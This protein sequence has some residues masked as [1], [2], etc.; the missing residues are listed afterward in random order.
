MI[1]IFFLFSF[2]LVSRKLIP[3]R[4]QR[5]KSKL[6]Q[7]SHHGRG[8][9][10]FRR[11]IWQ[12]LRKNVGHH[13]AMPESRSH[14]RVIRSAAFIDHNS[15]HE[16][17]A[18]SSLGSGSSS[19]LGSGSSVHESSWINDG[20]QAEQS[21]TPKE[22]LKLHGSPAIAPTHKTKTS[23]QK[24]KPESSNSNVGVI[25]LLKPANRRASRTA[26]R[27][28][29][30]SG[31]AGSGSS[32]DI[33]SGVHESSGSEKIEEVIINPNVAQPQ[34][35]QGH[36]ETQGSGSITCVGDINCAQGSG[37]MEMNDGQIMASEKFQHSSV[38]PV[39]VPGD[40]LNKAVNIV[41]HQ[42]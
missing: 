9:A 27:I 5:P 6:D 24:Q 14:N 39:Y 11:S 23:S 29:T 15:K 40:Q 3:E 30:G 16:E 37:S 7:G 36:G 20:I 18:D 28:F 34:F 2:L 13:K 41:Y 4:G 35:A 10:I 42:I 22:S 1:L 38:E 12:F 33:D 8:V 31:D 19:G 25:S 21:Q 17:Y 26:R 32:N